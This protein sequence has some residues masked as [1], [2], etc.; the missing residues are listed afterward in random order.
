MRTFLMVGI[1][2]S[3]LSGTPGGR[4]D[5]PRGRETEARL[6][7]RLPGGR[8]LQAT[9]LRDRPRAGREGRPGCPGG[10][11]PLIT[12]EAMRQALTELK[13]QAA[14]AAKQQ[15]EEQAAKNLAEGKVFLAE[16]AGR[17]E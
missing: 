7:H 9:G 11:E 13:L 2:L 14:A 16:N 12:P 8:R 15:R 3:L 6:Q 4:R 10:S 5:G 1:A 17:R